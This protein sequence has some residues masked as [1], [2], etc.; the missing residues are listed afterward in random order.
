M[1]FGDEVF[2]ALSGD[3]GDRGLGWD[4]IDRLSNAAEDRSIEWLIFRCV[5]DKSKVSVFLCRQNGLRLFLD[6]TLA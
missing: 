6:Q 2:G 5:F 3:G 4:G 1:D